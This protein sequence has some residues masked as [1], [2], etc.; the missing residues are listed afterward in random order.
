MAEQYFKE[1]VDRKGYKVDSEDRAIFEKEIS[2]SNFGLGCADMIEF[3]LYDSANNQLPQGDSGELVRYIFIDDDN[4][5]D[6]FIISKNN[7][8][9][10]KNDTIEFIVDLEKLITEA[11]YANGIFRTQVTLLNRRTGIENIEGNNLWV[12]EISPSRT[13]IRLLPNRAKG[14]NKDLEKRYSMFTDEKNFRDD[15][16]YYVNVFIENINLQKVLE[17]FFLVKGKEEDGVRYAKLILKEFKLD[18]FELLLQRVKTKFIESMQYYSQKRIWDINDNRYGKPIGPDYDCV[19]LSISD[20]ENASFESLI[21]CIDFY[22]PKRDI[23]T[24]SVLTKEEQITLDKVKQILKSSTS[25]A[26]YE[27]TE[28]DSAEVQGCTDP[29][30]LNYNKYATV[31]DGSCMYPDIDVEIRGCTDPNALNYNPNATVDD[32]S[33]TFK[34]NTETKNYYI[35]SDAG[36]IKYRTSNGK[37]EEKNGVMY[38]SFSCT[39]IVGS[40]TFKG[41]VREYPKLKPTNTSSL[42]RLRNTRGNGIDAIGFNDINVDYNPFRNNQASPIS[43]TYK[44]ASGASQKTSYISTGEET[45]ICAQDGSIVGFPGISVTRIG[46]CTDGIIPPDIV[47]TFDEIPN[48]EEV[49]VFGNDPFGNVTSD[50]IIINS[51]NYR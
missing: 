29:N 22:L 15:T 14:K 51:T 26:V 13:E 37:T 5:N 12:H 28:P 46:N 38:D 30:S 19:E 31:D 20:I 27:S 23:K 36:T 25:N 6:Y 21:R 48:F 50:N 35:H 42:Y 17:D 49:V 3:I 39:H 10:K 16:I 8:T 40:V 2:K 11:G 18:S 34:P 45:T 44:D 24:K 32:G 7:K 41:D 1:I 33:C 43:L 9:K 47:D 4:V